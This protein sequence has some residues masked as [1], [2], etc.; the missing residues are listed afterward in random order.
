MCEGDSMFVGWRGVVYACA[1]VCENIYIYIYVGGRERER[2]IRIRVSVQ[3]FKEGERGKISDNGKKKARGVSAWQAVCF[4]PPV[5]C[6]LA[7]PAGV[8]LTFHPSS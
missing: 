1:C 4:L 5:P 7:N 3:V 8:I 2:V 6:L